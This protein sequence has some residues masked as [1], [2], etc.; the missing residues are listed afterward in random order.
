MPIIGRCPICSCTYLQGLLSLE[1][2][3]FKY[4]SVLDLCSYYLLAGEPKRLGVPIDI[5]MEVIQN[6]RSN[7]MIERSWET[8]LIVRP[9]QQNIM[10]A[11][12]LPSYEL[13]IIDCK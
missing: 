9:S 12:S 4:S 11:I 2:V 1:Q 13:R 8:A 5:D 10:T 6:K 3:S 7:E